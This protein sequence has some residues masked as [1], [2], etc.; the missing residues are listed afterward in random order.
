MRDQ[1]AF[2]FYSTWPFQKIS[3]NQIK[4]ERIDRAIRQ[5]VGVHV[6]GHPLGQVRQ[7]DVPPVVAS[8]QLASHTNI[9]LTA[10]EDYWMFQFCCR[11]HY[12]AT[13][14]S[15]RRDNFTFSIHSRAISWLIS[16]SFRRSPKVGDLPVGDPPGDDP[17]GDITGSVDISNKIWNSFIVVKVSL[18]SPL[19]H[20]LFKINESFW[21]QD[22]K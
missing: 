19:V 8:S 16:S 2:N 22:S 14:I 12:F 4:P 3:R 11:W 18:F 21:L 9:G 13:R 7:W 1:A 20:I 6:A 17:P 10:L 5:G 15:G